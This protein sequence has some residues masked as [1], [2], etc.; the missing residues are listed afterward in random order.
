MSER[1]TEIRPPLR[2]RGVRH[3]P[4][5]ADSVDPLDEMSVQIR[6]L[7]AAAERTAARIAEA[8]AGL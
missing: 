2:G 3:E 8:A 4:G 7:D 1:M 6:A 5:A